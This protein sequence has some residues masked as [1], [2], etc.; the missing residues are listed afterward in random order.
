MARYTDVGFIIAAIFLLMSYS[1]SGPDE[2]YRG[3]PRWSVGECQCAQPGD[4]CRDNDGVCFRANYKCSVIDPCDDGYTCERPDGDTEGYGRC[5][6]DDPAEC[7]RTCS[8]HRDCGPQEVC[9][10][11]SGT[12]VP[13]PHC[14]RQADCPNGTVCTDGATTKGFSLVC[15]VP[16]AVPTGEACEN[17]PECASGLCDAESGACVRRCRSNVD[18]GGEDVCVT[19][20]DPAVGHVAPPPH[21]ESKDASPCGWGCDADAAYCRGDKCVRANC[22]V[23]ADCT[24]DSSPAC[25]LHPRNPFAGFCYSFEFYGVASCEPDEFV[26]DLGGACFL[27]QTC[28]EEADCPQY[29]TCYHDREELPWDVFGMCGRRSV[30]Q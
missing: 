5:V 14:F 4:A 19:V 28:E 17:N 30:G 11:D 3:A 29:Y 24:R 7:G 1:C 6:C 20:A 26:S 8:R 21:C 16:G 10:P 22:V 25:A 13:A 15:V 27:Y 2:G 23:S 9:S 12:C 18:C